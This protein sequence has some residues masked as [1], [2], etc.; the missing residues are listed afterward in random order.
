[1][2]QPN[3]TLPKRKLINKIRKKNKKRMNNFVKSFETTTKNG[4]GSGLQKLVNETQF[5]VEFDY[6]NQITMGQNRKLKKRMKKLK[7][8]I[9]ELPNSNEKIF[10]EMQKYKTSIVKT[11]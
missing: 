4:S 11:Q 9:G 1:M 6:V 5:N 10:N 2:T 7:K 3:N 8:K